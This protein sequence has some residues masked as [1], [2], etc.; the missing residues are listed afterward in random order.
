MKFFRLMRA[1]IDLAPL[2][3]EIEAN[4]AAWLANTS[5]QDMI[6]VQRDTN[7][8]ILRTQTHSPDI[9]TNDNQESCAAE[10][11]SRFPKAM[12]LMQ[13][14]AEEMKA[15]LSRAI[16]A[17]LKPHSQVFG[18][19]DV[20]TY[21]FIRDRYH[22][23]LQS[24]A[25]SLLTSGDE[26][27][28]MKEGEL[29]WF[30]N[31]QFHEAFNESDQWRI[32]IVFDLL[33]QQYRPLAVNRLPLP[34]PSASD[35]ETEA[36]LQRAQWVK[37][38]QQRA[39]LHAPDHRLKNPNGSNAAWLVD[40]RRIFLDA[41]LLDRLA[42]NFWRLF[43][44]KMPFQIGGM[45]VAAVPLI[46][47]ILM[48]SAARGSRVNG[49]II[50]KERKTY[51]VGNQI[52]GEVTDAPIVIIDD[53]L[54]SGQSLEKVRVILADRGKR[55]A[56]IF[57]VVD[58]CS[59]NGI[60]WRQHHQIPVV[61]LITLEDLGLATTRKAAPMPVEIFTPVWQYRAEDPNFNIRVPKSF[62]ALAE[63]RIYFGTDCGDFC[64]L[65][66][67]TG[68][69]AW[70][71][72]IVSDGHKNIFSAP[73]VHAGR[74][75]F[76]GYD[77]NVYCLDARSGE[78]IWRYSGCDWVGSSPVISAELG[79]LF[80]GLEYALEGQMGSVIA[81]DCASGEPVWEYRTKRYTHGSP[82]LWP[83]RNLLACGS[84]D[85]ELLLFDAREGTLRWRFQTRGEGRKGSVRHAPAFDRKRNQIVTGSAD[86]YVYVI[87]IA[88]GAEIWSL[89]TG[90]EV[91]TIPLIVEDLLFVGSTDKC[92]YIIDL[93]K[94]Q[95]IKSIYTGSKIYSPPTLVNAKI[96]FGSCNGIIYEIDLDS[97]EITGTHQLPDAITNK[98]AYS[99]QYRLF[100]A[101][102]YTNQLHCLRPL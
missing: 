19:V 22:L 21:Y 24:E 73:L 75:Y 54:N 91:Y 89:K 34:L 96:Y 35:R 70:K 58:F 87:D 101:L 56:M 3:A 65:D 13:S 72:K 55:I 10:I 26:Q 44:D 4:D 98:I 53:L 76:G 8:I 92:F 12:A 67:L 62:P 50:R 74:V 32:H 28:R 85:D 60:A 80:I 97:L 47:A 46:S 16:I 18:H 94:N 49:F 71:F 100:Y 20:G 38:I 99:E 2:L 29:W 37:I 40:M 17:R 1:N 48:R 59:G 42:D 33:P 5:R 23:V 88:S 30:D 61:S 9:R 36:S 14:F 64:C 11:A 95:M 6:P 69:V 52:E 43:G 93:A 7:S 77:G 57:V 45:E 68:A 81:L 63:D 82:A 102:T 25:G 15:D 83:E 79:M 51:G 66:A 90:D 84:N 41:A 78:E 39:V 86:G 31:K 27:V